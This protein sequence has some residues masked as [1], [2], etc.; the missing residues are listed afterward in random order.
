MGSELD[1]TVCRKC[2]V[3]RQICMELETMH[4]K[5]QVALCWNI[6]LHIY[7]HIQCNKFFICQFNKLILVDDVN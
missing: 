4:G 6:Y 3:K 1:L 2:F 7:L 5:Y